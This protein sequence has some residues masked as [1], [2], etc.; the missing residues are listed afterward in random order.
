M[1]DVDTKPVVKKDFDAFVRQVLEDGDK[2]PQPM[3]ED[4]FRKEAF[5]FQGQGNCIRCHNLPQKLEFG[6]LNS[7]KGFDLLPTVPR[8]VDPVM[9][10]RRLIDKFTSQP[11][12][13]KTATILNRLPHKI[14]MTFEKGKTS[15]S[16]DFVKAVEAIPGVK[17]D[18][19][20]RDYLSRLK[21]VSL[22]NGKYG[23]KLD[24]PIDLKIGTLAADISFDVAYDPSK[25]EGVGLKGIQGLSIFNVDIDEMTV[26]TDNGKNEITVSGLMFGRRITTPIDLTKH[27]VNGEILKNAIGQLAEYKPMLEN[28]D[29]G[30]FTKDIPEGFKNTVTDMVKGVSSIS[31][32]GDQ[33]TLKR[34]NGRATFD[35]NGPTVDVN[36][37][38][39]FKIGSDSDSPSIKDL[40]GLSVSFPLPTELEMGSKYSTNIKGV[41]LGYADRNGGR[42]IQVDT[43]NLTDYIRVR[44]GGDFKPQTDGRG[45]WNLNVRGSN[46]LSEDR[47][48]KMD[49]DVRIGRNGN[50]NMEPSEVLD[51][52]SR[53]TWQ[54]ADLSPAGGGFAI[55]AVATKVGSWFSSWF[56]E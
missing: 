55:T 31:K 41:S 25:P 52:V 15:V 37:E 7:L 19:E 6:G 43:D 20:T 11:I 26:R 13:E 28:R 1:P 47:S 51:I 56:L 5:V 36:P 46:P 45:N 17:L 48:D 44:V 34:N 4:K 3:V 39:T 2:A 29:F 18:A 14:H 9:A 54:A 24:R 50:V 38:V 33:Y 40:R 16:T 27:G 42:S 10:E 49:I 53:L 8:A 22:E 32:D 23:M 12:I 30:K 21:T 35:F